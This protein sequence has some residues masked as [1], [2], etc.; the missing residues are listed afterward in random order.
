MPL[1]KY[2]MQCYSNGMEGYMKGLSK[3]KALLGG[4]GFTQRGYEHMENLN[5]LKD[6]TK[7]LI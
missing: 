5:K 7:K 6:L 1:D 4:N 3:E 2:Q